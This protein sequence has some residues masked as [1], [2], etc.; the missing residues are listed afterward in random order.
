MYIDELRLHK[1]FSLDFIQITYF[2]S[3]SFQITYSLKCVNELQHEILSQLIIWS[4]LGITRVNKK[5]SA[6]A[7]VSKNDFDIFHVK[8]NFDLKIFV[9]SSQFPLLRH[10]QDNS[11]AIDRNEMVNVLRSI[12]SMVSIDTS[13]FQTIN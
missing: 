12:Y 4:T 2:V 11:K 9:F 10:D 6:A 5:P 8:F 3:I 13:N 7:D 1:V